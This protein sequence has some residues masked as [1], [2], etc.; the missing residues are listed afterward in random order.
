M[1]A[2]HSTPEIFALLLQFQEVDL[3]STEALHV[4]ARI[5]DSFEERLPMLRYLLGLGLDPNARA[6]HNLRE[7]LEL[8]LGYA[9]RGG[10]TPAVK[11]LLEAG[12]DPFLK[13]R[14][15]MSPYDRAV[16]S[17]YQELAV[18]YLKYGAPHPKEET[19]EE[20]P[21]LYPV[22][23]QWIRRHDNFIKELRSI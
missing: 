10:L 7:R 11:C 3:E 16:R 14:F 2:Q 18:E 12:A 19:K 13:N 17:G 1:L 9:D 5:Y 22:E 6:E 20:I 15:G 4:A 23:Y 8:P 21:A